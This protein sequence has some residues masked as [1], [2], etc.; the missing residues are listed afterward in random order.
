MGSTSTS[1]ELLG[2]LIGLA[3]LFGYA[4][5][6]T[7]TVRAGRDWAKRSPRMAALRDWDNRRP[8]WQ[9]TLWLVGITVALVIVILAIVVLASVHF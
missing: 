8:S 5:V 6:R 3:L 4:Y 1:D 2:L 9:G 7:R